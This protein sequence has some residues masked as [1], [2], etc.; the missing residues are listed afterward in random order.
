[1]R[2]LGDVFGDLVRRFGAGV[3]AFVAVVVLLIVAVTVA[4]TT[5]GGKTYHLTAYFTRTVGLYT[6]NDVRIM[7]VKVGK[8]ESITPVGPQVKVVMAYD[9]DDRVLGFLGELLEKKGMRFLLPAFAELASSRPVRLVLVGGVRGDAREAFEAFRATAPEAASRVHVVD[10]A[11]SPKALSRLLA[12]CDFVVFPSLF[13]GSARVILEA[14][15]T[16]LPVITTP[17][18]CD[19]HWVVDRENGFRVAAGDVS[20]LASRMAELA[21]QP[22]L[23]AE[24]G[25]RGFERVRRYTWTTYGD[26]CA[27]T[28]RALLGLSQC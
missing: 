14:M 4:V 25:A 15:A 10:Y 24:M 13:E 11:R 26:R 9:G 20:V 16:G 27:A 7:G 3:V 18:A 22:A 12:L 8:I 6:G 28:C 2:R 1:M 5:G 21:E 17:A 23:R 19:E